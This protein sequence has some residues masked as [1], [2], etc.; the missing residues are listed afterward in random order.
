LQA[1]AALGSLLPGGIYAKSA[2]GEIS[3]SST[4]AA[5][6]AQ[7]GLRPCMLAASGPLTGDPVVPGAAR[8]IVR[9]FFYESQG[10]S[11]IEP[12]RRR[13]YTLLSGTTFSGSQD[14]I[15][16]VTWADDV[17]DARDDALRSSL[18]VSRYEVAMR[19]L[20]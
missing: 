6:D 20:S 19:R 10:A 2:V 3:R 14:A 11:A 4:P 13:A 15:Y 18:I 8:Q 16:E 12:A 1:D 7:R 5:F 17:L 9:L